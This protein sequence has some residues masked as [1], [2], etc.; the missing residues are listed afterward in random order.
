MFVLQ[1]PFVMSIIIGLQNQAT[2]D[3]NAQIV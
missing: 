2:T 1:I 3:A